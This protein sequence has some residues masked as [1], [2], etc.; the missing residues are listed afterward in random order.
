[1]RVLYFDCPMGAAGDMISASLI[2]LFEDKKSIIDELNAIG[3]EN[4]EFKVKDSFKCG[5]KGSNFEVLVNGISE[6]DYFHHHD[7][8]HHDHDHEHRHEHHHEHRS[9]SDISKIIDELNLES[10]VKEDVVEIYR[11]I[12]EAESKAHNVEVSEIHFHEVGA[13]DAIADV[14]AASYLINKLNVEKIICS[15]INVGSGLVKCAHGILPVPTPATAY[16]LKDV[17]IYSS[18][19]KSELCTPTGAAILKHFASEFSNLKTMKTEKIG[20]GMGKKDFEVANCVRSFLGYMDTDEIIYELAFNVDDMTGEEISFAMDRFFESGAREVY[21]IAIGMKKSRPGN[22][23]CVICSE[24]HKA[25]IINSIF[26]HTSTIGLREIET[27]RYV[28][29]RDISKKSCNLGEVRVKK[30]SGY[31]TFKEKYEFDD[32][33]KIAIENSM[34]LK[35]VRNLLKEKN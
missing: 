12:A 7:H 14:T 13:M 2:E 30:S 18:Q 24:K 16:I 22:K 15:P 32:L 33:S 6:F 20:Y 35:E 27:K 9:M 29:N 23:I 5:I 21:T 31:G 25:E 26:K 8:E 1:M 4:V 34:S 3:I 10:K 17:P 11:L 28:L 19:I